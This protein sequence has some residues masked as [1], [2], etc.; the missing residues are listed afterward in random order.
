MVYPGLPQIPSRYPSQL[1]LQFLLPVVHNEV[2][3]VLVGPV[4]VGAVLH[5]AC[6]D[7]SA[8]QAKD[9]VGVGGEVPNCSHLPVGAWEAAKN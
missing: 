5:S 6:L 2:G 8:T 9:A 3:C 7:R 1:G 4:G